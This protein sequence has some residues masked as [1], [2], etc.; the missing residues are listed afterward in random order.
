MKYLIKRGL[1]DVLW[2]LLII[3]VGVSGLT[4]IYAIT[5]QIVVF[6]AL[7]VSVKFYLFLGAILLA[8]L[9]RFTYSLVINYRRA[10]YVST[11]GEYSF[12]HAAKIIGNYPDAF[13]NE[14]E[15]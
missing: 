12:D 11:L 4:F 14:Q 9:V 5:D 6:L 13:E 7:L 2:L 8:C 3:V 1:I 15:L 10:K